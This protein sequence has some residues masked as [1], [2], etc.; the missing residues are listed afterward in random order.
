MTNQPTTFD[1]HDPLANYIL[2]VLEDFIDEIGARECTA[3]FDT[4]VDGK[5]FLKGQNLIQKPERFIEDHLVFPMLRQA[6]GY[7]LRPQPKQYAPRWPRGGGI[8]DFAVTSIPI[9]V[10]MQ[11][12][13]RFFGEVKPPKK[14]ENARNDMENYLD[15]DLDIHAVAILSDGFDWEL[16]I[17]PK[18]E[19]ID[20]LDNPFQE[21]S[22]RDS[23]R[24]VRTR[25]MQTASYRP[26]EVRSDIDTDAFSQFT[27]DAVLD[28]I[29]TEFEVPFT[30]F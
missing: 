13:I 27:V 18:G 24:T 26:H 30:P 8:P 29:E 17:R 12:D 15:S 6:F 10:A 1:D 25:N 21:A 9:E 7:S 14:I 20:D 4:V 2:N 3:H 23:L 16:W 11:Q 28:V 19:S 5:H 22:L